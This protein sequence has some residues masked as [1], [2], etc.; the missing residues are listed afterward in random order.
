MEATPT[1]RSFWPRR[2]LRWLL[3]LVI[4]ALIFGGVTWFQTRH[5]LSRG[6]PLPVTELPQL[7]AER[8][9]LTTFRGK[10]TLLYF[11]AP[12]CGVCKT[13]AHNVSAVVGEDHH[14]ASVALSY[15]NV[16]QV[17]SF[18]REY[19]MPQPVLLG[20]TEASTAFNVEAFPTVY[21]LNREGH[22]AFA[23][24]GY[25]SEIGLRARL[26]AAGF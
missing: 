25:T 7:D 1:P 6:T 24:M 10:P 9:D 15:E 8:V 18:A 5:L 14:V 23:T 19:N 11:W 4:F 17:R 20:G 2:A 26:W 21:V 12:W 22:V 16:E 3:E 13:N